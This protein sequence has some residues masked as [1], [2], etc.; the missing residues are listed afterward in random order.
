MKKYFQNVT[1][2]YYEDFL[3][4]DRFILNKVLSVKYN[5]L[6]ADHMS[7]MIIQALRQKKKNKEKILKD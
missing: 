4:L 5:H 7:V 3:L 2:G 1:Y 6:K